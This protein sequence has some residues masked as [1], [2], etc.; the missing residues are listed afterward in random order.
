MWIGKL[1]ELLGKLPKLRCW[2][3]II[4]K[5]KKDCMAT[6]P[7]YKRRRFYGKKKKKMKKWKSPY[8]PKDFILFAAFSYLIDIYFVAISNSFLIFFIMWRERAYKNQKKTF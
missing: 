7:I 8:V 6:Y 5:E 3:P 2:F 4:K 1:F